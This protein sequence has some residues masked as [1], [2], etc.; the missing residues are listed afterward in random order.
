[1]KWTVLCFLS[2]ATLL[3][4]EKAVVEDL[5][6]CGEKQ[7]LRVFVRDTLNR[8][9]YFK[10]SYTYINDT[11]LILKYEELNKPSA[12]VVLTDDEIDS[13]TFSTNILTVKAFDYKD[14]LLLTE[15]YKVSRDSCHVR[16]LEG[17]IY[18]TIR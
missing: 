13:L 11:D 15:T 14:S 12:L 8:P 7:Y 1:M 4:C 2:L 17:P 5:G 9:Y 10:T 3:S 18:I 6:P 16:Y